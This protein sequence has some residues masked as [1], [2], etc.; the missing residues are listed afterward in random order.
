MTT[1]PTKATELAEAI[2]LANAL[3]LY[4]TGDEHQ[5][6]IENAAAE[7]LR[8]H[9]DLAHA[10]RYAEQLG[11]ELAKATAEIADLRALL[12]AIGAGGVSP[13]MGAAGDAVAARVTP[14]SSAKGVAHG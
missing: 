13:L 11:R 6:D 7:L 9:A 10:D 14:P 8:L 1:Q 3:D 12:V 4:A 2:R 5:R